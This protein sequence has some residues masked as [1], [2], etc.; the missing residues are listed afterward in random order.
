MDGVQVVLQRRF[1]AEIQTSMDSQ[2][3]WFEW[4][5]ETPIDVKEIYAAV[6]DGG[7]GLQSMQ[8]LG[9][10][11]FGDG[12]ARL[13]GNMSAKFEY[14]GTNPGNGKWSIEVVGYADE[15]PP[16]VYAI[17][18]FEQPEKYQP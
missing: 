9:E 10:W 4:T 13:K 16:A 14:G 3:L 2:V 6:N 12:W 18:E 5:R 15:D 1:G 11:E 17:K 8:L 7:M